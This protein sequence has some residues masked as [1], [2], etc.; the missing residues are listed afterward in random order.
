MTKKKGTIVPTEEECYELMRSS[1]MLENI[2]RHSVQVMK[3]SMALVGA[4]RDPSSI[5]ADLVKAGALLHDIAKTR[6]IGSGEMRHD[7][8]G[9]RIMR[10]LGYDAV[11]RIVE[12][13]VFF[14]GFDP[15][16]PLKEREI[17]FYADKRVMHD[18]IVSLDDRVN[19]LVNRYGSTQR[20]V[21]L[22]LENKQF[23]LD[24]ELKLQSHLTADIEDLLSK[25]R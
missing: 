17:V 5:N 20:I 16:G 4:L 21:T 24:L 18:M 15:R 2:V 23:V 7:L 13:H 6:T 25:I 1:G 10:D 22:I 9:G 14:D 19:D 11:A 3:V 8:I 12:A